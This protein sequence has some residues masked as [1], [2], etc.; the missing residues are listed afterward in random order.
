MSVVLPLLQREQDT[1]NFGISVQL[2][3]HG[4][5]ICEEWGFNKKREDNH[6]RWLSMTT[7]CFCT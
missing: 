7:K 5:S 3:R 1:L 4:G 6:V 2:V